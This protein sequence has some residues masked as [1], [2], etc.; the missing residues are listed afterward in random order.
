M[1]PDALQRMLVMRDA[2]EC[3][4]LCGADDGED[5]G[6]EAAHDVIQ[7]LGQRGM[8]LYA[9]P[10]PEPLRAPPPSL[11]ERLSSGAARI[12]RRT[13]TLAAVAVGTARRRA[14]RRKS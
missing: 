11:G 5:D 8:I 10:D 7:A 12:G 14:A 1:T 3:A 13:F 2:L 9:L 6:R 4:G